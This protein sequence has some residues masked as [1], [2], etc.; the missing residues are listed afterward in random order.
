M[1][2]TKPVGTYEIVAED[3]ETRARAG[4]L[5][6]AHG[7]VPTPIFMP[8]GTRASVKG[9]SQEQLRDLDAKIILGNTYHLYL[10]PG[11][12]LIESFGGLHGFMNWDR[13]ILTDSGGFQV[14]SLAKSRKM[15]EEGVEFASVLDGS[16]HLFTPEKSMQIQYALGSDIIMT[17]DE[18]APSRYTYDQAKFSTDRTH[19]WLDRSMAELRRLTEEK[20]GHKR[21][22]F[23]IVQGGIHDPLKLESAEYCR[24]SGSDGV[25]IGG[26]LKIESD[27]PFMY[28]L[29]SKFID[30]LPRSK[31][32]YLMGAG[33]VDN[34]V[35][36]VGLGIDMYD[37]VY[38]TRMARHGVAMSRYGNIRIVAARYRDSKEPLDPTCNCH[39][40]RTYSKG[41]IRHLLS[42]GEQFGAS[43]VSYH[44]LHTLLQLARDMREAIIAGRYGEFLREYRS[45][46]KFQA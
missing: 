33:A 34:L 23:S 6:T 25:G 15:S 7:I 20:G 5:H 22:F 37:C 32:R 28:D 44:N 43:L 46:P 38:P 45:T 42:V 24:D 30:T 27:A 2:E 18:C 41:Y 14:Y 40:C 21:L 13:P 12:E 4:L 36:G 11:E 10:R 39:V 9:I 1:I 19:R 16:R 31:P 26:D 35:E 8:V 17:F 29:I 3:P